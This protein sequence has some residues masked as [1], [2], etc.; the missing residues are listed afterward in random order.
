MATHLNPTSI[1]LSDVY[2]GREHVKD[3]AGWEGDTT[4]NA[5]DMDP[6]IGEDDYKADLDS[7]NIIGRME[8]G[9]T[10]SQASVS[11]YRD[12]NKDSTTRE[13]EFV[14]NKDWDEV[15]KTIYD[16]LVPKEAQKAFGEDGTRK[17]IAESY[18]DVSNFLN[19]IES[20]TG[21]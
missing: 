17:Y 9:Q 1:Q 15:K 16:S 5:N 6:S 14:K 10:Y 12:V 2:G 8:K 20:A 4:F 18:K 19:R 13:K 3:L 11:Y 21:K 7:V